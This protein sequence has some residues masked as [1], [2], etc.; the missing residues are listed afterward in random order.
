MTKVRNTNKP[1]TSATKATKATKA[2]EAAADAKTRVEFSRSV[3]TILFK[4]TNGRCSV[5]RCLN[6]T[7]GPFIDNEGA[8]NMGIA[9][10]I[11]SASPNGPRGQG[12]K[13]EAFLESAQNGIWCC[14]KHGS[15]ID[16]NDGGDYPAETLFAWKALAE[17]RTLKEMNDQPSPLGWVESIEFTQ[18]RGHTDGPKIVLSRNSLLLGRNGSG[19]TLLLE[20]VASVS[21]EEFAWR[22]KDEISSVQLA[23]DDVRIKVVYSTVDTPAKVVRI[24]VAGTR[25][26]R[27]EGEARTQ[28]P[29]ADLEVI[30]AASWVRGPTRGEG[31]DDV[32]MLATMLC[33]DRATVFAL[34]EN[35]RREFVPFPFQW[36]HVHEVELEHEQEDDYDY[37]DEETDGDEAATAVVPKYKENG[38]PFLEVRCKMDEDGNYLSFE[39]LSSSEQNCVILELLIAKARE[40]CKH[41]LTLLLIDAESAYRLSD[42]GFE[43][44]LVTLAGEEFQSVVALPGGREDYAEKIRT[45]TI[46]KALSFLEPWQVVKVQNGLK[47]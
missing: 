6:P 32:D 35:E 37:D 14:T 47:E 1:K 20:A 40:T 13:D 9:C 24:N 27:F 29:P 26:A 23:E 18:F 19:K 10:H 38:E 42:Y 39:S 46:P 16:K 12:G 4:R 34:L 3:K 15:L 7:M 45:N 44:L 31:E 8:V 30:F 43:R 22:F 5:P 21:H 17:A 2:T 25:V 36:Q 33:V 41:R 11:Y 28:L